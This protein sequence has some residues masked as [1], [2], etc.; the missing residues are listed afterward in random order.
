MNNKNILIIE[1]PFQLL[2]AFE[3][4]N[5]FPAKNNTLFVRFSGSTGNDAQL[6]STLDIIKLPKNVEV[7]TFTINATNRS[8]Y[9]VLK[10]VFFWVRIIFINR[11]EGFV[12]VGDYRSRFLQLV[13]HI[14]SKTILL[15]DGLSTIHIQ[16][17]FT[18]NRFL[19]WFTIFDLTPFHGQK[20]FKNR[21]KFLNAF[22]EN[23]NSSKKKVLLFIGSKL[24]EENI[25]SEDE[26]V[27]LVTKIAQKYSNQQ[28]TYIAH[29]TESN[30]KLHRIETI[31]NI[32][33]I[34]LNYPLEL[35][36][37]FGDFSPFLILSFFSTALITL[38]KI[39]KVETVA[40]RFDYSKSKNHLN[41]QKAYDY[42]QKY[43]EVKDI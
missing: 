33:I 40:Y 15:D 14:S 19:N 22:V 28:I 18:K 36:P 5:E 37:L 25:I 31:K 21:F 35:L 8:I 10:I 6:K 30:K 1:T 42:C 3:A 23:R 12:F 34:K 41:I 38:E 27:E 20:I 16:D 7:K 13:I 26:N 17:S 9:D 2:N 39:F 4:I 11:I 32:E 43:I 24:S 29:R